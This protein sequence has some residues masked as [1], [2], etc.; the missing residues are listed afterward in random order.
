ML[1]RLAE[2]FAHPFARLFA[3]TDPFSLYTLAGALVCALAWYVLRRP[4]R[5]L[6]R[7]AAFLRAGFS[8]RVLRHRSSILDYKLFF[9]TSV[10]FGTGVIGLFISSEAVAMLV[11]EGLK[12]VLGPPSPA[13][14]PHFLL[15]LVVTVAIVLVVDLGYWLAHWLMHRLPLFWEFHKLHHSAEVMTPATEWRQHPVELIL[16]PA[17]YAVTVGPLYGGFSYFFG[18]AAQ[19]FTLFEVNV[20]TLVLMMT[21]LHLRHTHLWIPARGWLGYLVQ[22]PAHHQIH[23]SDQKRHWGKNL[24][25]FLSVWDWAFGTLYVPNEAEALQFGIGP[26]GR[27]HTGVLAAYWTPMMKAARHFGRA[28]KP[29]SS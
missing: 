20:A 29:A 11:A 15:S 17:G 28:R 12:A 25:L 13:R 4:R 22:S 5:P 10:I 6:R 21:I 9:M 1:E 3:I 18:A 27:E 23:H 8:P 19:P 2:A 26:E 16:F 14:E 24:G 7:M